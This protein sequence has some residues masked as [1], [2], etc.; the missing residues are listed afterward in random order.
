MRR[1]KI[2]LIPDKCRAQSKKL[3]GR[4]VSHHFEFFREHRP[5]TLAARNDSRSGIGQKAEGNIEED[6]EASVAL[7]LRSVILLQRSP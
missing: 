2:L 1:I 4:F 3:S 7:L 5:V 6:Y